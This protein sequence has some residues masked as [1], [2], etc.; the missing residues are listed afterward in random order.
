MSLKAVL[1]DLDDT[2]LWDDRSVEEAFAA[3]CAEAAK[4]VDVN[5]EELE[6]SVRKEARSLYESFETFPF[7]KMI[8]INPFEGLWANFTEGE[9]ENFRKLQKLAPGYRT[10]SWTRGLA[11]LGVEDR[12]LGHKLGEFFAAD[13]RTR[14]YVYEETFRVL[15]ALKGNYKLLLLTNGSPDLQKEKL[16][17]VPEIASYFDH[18]VISGDFGQGKPAVSIFKYAMGLLD[19][20]AEEG[21][22]IGDKLTTDILGS[23]SVGMRNIWINH[24]GLQAGDE[25]VPANEVKRLQEILPIITNG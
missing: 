18:I 2:L 19:I 11:A 3:T 16:A 5:P 1:F 20:E 22:M 25:I 12:E 10:E 4:H 14:P 8:G 7:T 17:G 24:H 23:N 13:R 9:D 15:D 21:I 6:A